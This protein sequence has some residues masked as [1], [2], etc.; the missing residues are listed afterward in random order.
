M[1]V[2]EHYTNAYKLPYVE[3]TQ[4]ILRLRQPAKNL[5]NTGCC[6]E[7]LPKAMANRDGWQDRVQGIYAVYMPR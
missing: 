2:Y 1:L 7:D 6:I 5:L 3:S 4:V